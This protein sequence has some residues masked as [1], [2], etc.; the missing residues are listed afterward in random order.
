VSSDRRQICVIYKHAVQF[1][2]GFLLLVTSRHTE[3]KRND[4]SC[5]IAGTNMWALWKTRL[6]NAPSSTNRHRLAESIAVS[7]GLEY[8]QLRHDRFLSHSFQFIGL[9][10]S[11]CP[12]I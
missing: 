1:S 12:R 6:M 8:L 7:L 2:S 9:D 3:T 11:A 5:F 4:S 10:M